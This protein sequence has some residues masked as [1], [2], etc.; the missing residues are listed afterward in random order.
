[1]HPFFK[2][3]SKPFFGDIILPLKPKLYTIVVMYLDGYK[4]EIY[5]I[6]KPWQYIEVVKKN[7][8]VKS[9]W[10]KDENKKLL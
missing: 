4:K 7:P 2:H 1:M 3:T 8:K 9:A 6:E 5:G 10:V